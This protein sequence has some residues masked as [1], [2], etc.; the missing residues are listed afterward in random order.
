MGRIRL[1]PSIFLFFCSV[2]ML[3]VTIRFYYSPTRAAS[4]DIPRCCSLISCPDY[5]ANIIDK[6]GNRFLL[7]RCFVFFLLH[8]C[9]YARVFVLASEVMM[10]PLSWLCLWHSCVQRCPHCS[11]GSHSA[12]NTD[13]AK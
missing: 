11:P 4:S 5:L 3:L 13:H 7:L 2:C 10:V 8:V 12:F 1:T 9:V 6:Q